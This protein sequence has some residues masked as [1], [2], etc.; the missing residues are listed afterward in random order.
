MRLVLK[1]PALSFTYSPYLLPGLALLG[2]GIYFLSYYL[3]LESNTVLGILLM[4]YVFRIIQPGARTSTYALPAFLILILTFLLDSRSS[5]YFGWVLAVLFLLQHA[6]GRLNHLI[7]FLALFCS[8][9]FQYAILIFGFPI[10]LWL[11]QVTGTF[12]TQAGLDASIMGNVVILNGTEFSVDSG[13]MGLNMLHT[14][15]V[16]GLFIMAYFERKTEKHFSFLQVL[17]VLGLLT[18]LN[19]LSNFIRILLLVLFRLMPGNFLHDGVGIVCFLLYVI[20]PFY[21][22]CRFGLPYL[23]KDKPAVAIT[24]ISP[25]FQKSYYLHLILLLG[26]FIRLM[27]LP[28]AH[29][30]AVLADQRCSLPGYNKTKLSS[31]VIQFRKPDALVYVKPI[32]SFY[33]PEHTPLICWIGSGYTLQKITRRTCAGYT[34]YTGRLHKQ[35]DLLYTAWWFDN[36]QSK[37]IEQITWRWQALQGSSSFSLVNVSAETEQKLLRE[38]E[39]ILKRNIFQ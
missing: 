36:G 14:S 1:L 31:G 26:L 34:V 32:E 39:A 20:I 27:L 16:L 35:N 23:A 9:L 12:L 6:F 7:L 5:L 28:D 24:Q 15:L 25:L 13:C 17:F 10:R 21:Y 2:L 30:T 19:V 8:P 33:R 22:C 11:S 37:T 29:A 18:G 4:P 38:T 3:N